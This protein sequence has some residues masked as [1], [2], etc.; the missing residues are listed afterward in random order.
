MNQQKTIKGSI[1]FDGV[2]L[3]SGDKV[4]LTL[5]PSDPNTGI[6]FHRGDYQI[7]ATYGQVRNSR[8]CTIIGIDPERSVSTIEH[9]MAALAG[10]EIDNVIIKCDLE[11]PIMDGASETF[12]E[13][14]EEVGTIEQ[15]S[16]RKFLR[17]LKSITVEDQDRSA[18]LEPANGF[19]IDFEIDFESQAIANQKISLEFNQEDFRYSIAP[20]RTFGLMQ[21]VKALQEAGLIKGGSLDNAI[22]VDGNKVINKEGLR[23]DNEFVRHKVLDAIGDLY[24]AGYPIIGRFKGVRS[25]HSLNNKLLHKLFCD[26]SNYEI[27]T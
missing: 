4:S 8:L 19:F 5:S 1:N 3:H 20:A 17:I 9:L 12:I 16:Y 22:I 6:V 18:T 26:S 23:F 15:D 11:I 7:K 10:S 25:G 14:I 24:L 21:E 27:T 13:Q 2:G